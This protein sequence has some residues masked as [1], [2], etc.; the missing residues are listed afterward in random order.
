MHDLIC[1][2]IDYRASSLDVENISV[3]D[4]VVIKNVKVKNGNQRKFYMNLHLKDDLVLR[5]GI[6][7]YDE[8]QEGALTSIT[9][10]PL[11]DLRKVTDVTN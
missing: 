9:T 11:R 2:V 8:R 3:C 4:N 7:S 6:H 1:D 5:S 10:S